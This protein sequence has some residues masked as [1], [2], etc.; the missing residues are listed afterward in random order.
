MRIVAPL[1]LLLLLVGCSAPAAP[2]Q[3]E[4]PAPAAIDGDW[5]LTRTV[6]ATDDTAP[7]TIGETEQRW[8]RISAPTCDG[9]S[10]TGTLITAQ[11]E[12]V[13]ES[14]NGSE[15]DYTWDGTTLSYTPEPSTYDC[16]GA[17]G[18]LLLAGAY[19]VTFDVTF[20]AADAEATSFAGTM[21]LSFEPD[22]ALL[23]QMLEDKCPVVEGSTTFDAEL[24]RR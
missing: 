18:T 9:S 5:L 10:C 3:T 16:T 12:D 19:G 1:A 14:G 11:T 15:V 17:D 22:P 23:D 8:L 7:Y 20:T 4:A 6:T 2:T 13:L 21:V 24:A